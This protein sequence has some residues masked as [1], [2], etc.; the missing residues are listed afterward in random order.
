MA[1]ICTQEN[2]YSDDDLHKTIIR[3]LGLC[4]ICHSVLHFNSSPFIIP[5]KRVFTLIQLK[6]TVKTR[7][8]TTKHSV[9]HVPHCLQLIQQYLDTETGSQMFLF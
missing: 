8:D 2:Q 3:T 1:I 9:C 7:D 6:Q 5:S 4:V